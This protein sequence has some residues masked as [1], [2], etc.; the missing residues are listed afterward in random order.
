MAM[1]E[2]LTSSASGSV[3]LKPCI[4]CHQQKALSEFYPHPHTSDGTIN[5]CKEC[6]KARSKLR[7]Q[8]NPTPQKPVSSEYRAW[9]NMR[10]SCRVHGGGIC[11]RWQHFPNFLGDMGQKPSPRHS[12]ERINKRADFSPGNCYWGTKKEQASNRIDNH[13]IEH[14][15]VRRTIEQ[16]AEYANI[17]VGTLRYRLEQGWPIDVAISRHDHRFP[18]SH[19]VRPWRK[20]YFRITAGGE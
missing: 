19:R 2:G 8:Q 20:A 15:G 18:K 1:T 9:S 4:S 13:W 12:L 3:S 14:E 7:R 11:E 6:H 5:I 10:K 17:R 16:W